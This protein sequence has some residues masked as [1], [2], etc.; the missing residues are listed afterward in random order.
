MRCIAI[1][2]WFSYL[3]YLSLL[4]CDLPVSL[5]LPRLIANRRSPT[6]DPRIL[7]DFLCGGGQLFCN[8]YVRAGGGAAMLLVAVLCYC[9][10]VLAVH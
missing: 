5:D 9:A 6:R 2:S 4:D 10:V 1:V 7:A 8:R 3:T